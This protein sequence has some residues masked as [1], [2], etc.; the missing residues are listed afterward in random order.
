LEGESNVSRVLKFTDM[1]DI[2]RKKK[3]LQSIIKEWIILKDKTGG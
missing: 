1:K 3:A 2:E